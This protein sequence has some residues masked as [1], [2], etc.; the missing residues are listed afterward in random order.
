M[1]VPDCV[2]FE[3][4]VLHSLHCKFNHN[5]GLATYVKPLCP[6]N[7]WLS[8]RAFLSH[9]DAKAL[10]SMHRQL[11]YTSVVYS[12]RRYSKPG[13]IAHFTPY[14]GTHSRCPYARGIHGCSRLPDS[15]SP[16]KCS[17][18]YKA[19]KCEL[20]KTPHYAFH[21]PSRNVDVCL[22]KLQQ[23]ALHPTK[24]KVL[25]KPVF[26]AL[27]KLGYLKLR[28]Y[29]LLAPLAT[30]LGHGY[31]FFLFD[32]F[33]CSVPFTLGSR[34]LGERISSIATGEK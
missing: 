10:D 34:H 18:S 11:S 21:P 14:S 8:T 22:R 23:S 31:D 4:P 2:F 17:V 28:C 24:I 32:F 25:S 1:F 9:H 3:S 5:R 7:G 30:A 12:S 13:S 6:D 16:T 27:T 20:E 19:K 26:R 33:F 15:A 29:P